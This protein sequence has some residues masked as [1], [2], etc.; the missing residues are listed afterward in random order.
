MTS[1]DLLSYFM[2]KNDNMQIALWLANTADECLG[3]PGEIFVPLQSALRV[4]FSD[5]IFQQLSRVVDHLF[6]KYV[7][8]VI[9][10]PQQQCFPEGCVKI[11]DFQLVAHQN[12][13]YVGVVPTPPNLL[14]IRISGFNFYITGTLYGHLQPLPLLSMTVPTYGTLAISANQLVVEATFDI[15]KTVDNVP[16]IRVVSCSLINEVILA[17]VEN[18]GLFTII[19]NTKYQHEITI[20]TRQILEETLCITVNNV[21]NN[22]LNNQLLQIPTQISIL[23]LYQIFFENSDNISGQKMKR[24]LESESNYLKAPMQLKMQTISGGIMLQESQLSR[25]FNKASYGHKLEPIILNSSSTF[26]TNIALQKSST[27]NSWEN[28]RRKLSLLILSLSI[29]D[30]SATYGKFF[31]GLDGDVYIKAY[32]QTI[33]LYQ[34]PKMLRFSEVINADAVDLLISEYTINTLLLKAHIIDA[35]VFNVSSTTPV[36]GKL[37]RTS[38]GIDEV[39]LSDSIPEVA[40][41]YPNKQLQIIIRTTEPPRAIISADAA[42]VTLEGHATFFVEGTTEEIGLIPFSTTIQCNVISLP[43][44][45]AGLIKIRTL[46]FHEHIDFFGL[47]LQSLDSFKEATKGAMMKM[48]NGILREGISLNESATSRLSNTSISLVDR[49]I[50]LQTKFNIERSFYQQMPISV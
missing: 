10:P 38:C 1:N 19:V 35:F 34:R 3:T 22:E 20:K 24:T 4:R 7:K 44:R 46:Q 31:I 41:I 50:L 39:C 2:K 14:T 49:G 11:Q 8:Q 13:S 48:V 37:I 30:T 15:Q 32:D 21:V 26:P 18:M 12:P 40:E 29:L 42:I 43:G 28:S 9:I 47:T 36:L 5:D 23:D 17:W 33:N 16:Y 25:L 45:I 27:N 6:K